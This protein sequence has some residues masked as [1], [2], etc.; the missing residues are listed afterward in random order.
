M[1][2]KTKYDV[3]Y[4]FY[5]PRVLTTHEKRVIQHRED[6]GNVYNYYRNIE[7]LKT[8]VRHKIVRH[9]EICVNDTVTVEYW[10]TNVGENSLR[11]RYSDDEM[12]ITDPDVALVFAKRWRDEQQCEYF[13]QQGDYSDE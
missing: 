9:I 3:G 1:K 4:E 10:C 5:V 13:G 7:I 12:T 6:D 2:I 8:A 11:S